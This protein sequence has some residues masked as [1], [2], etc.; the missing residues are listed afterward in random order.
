MPYKIKK[1]GSKYKV[2]KEGDGKVMG[3]HDTK[4]EALKQLK[5]LYANEDGEDPRTKAMKKKVGK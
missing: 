2:V 1:S 4:K 3:T 5:A